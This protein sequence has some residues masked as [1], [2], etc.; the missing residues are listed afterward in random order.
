[1]I[2]HQMDFFNGHLE[3]EIQELRQSVDKMRKSMFAR[4]NELEKLVIELQEKE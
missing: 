2:S 4:I 1:M 3:S